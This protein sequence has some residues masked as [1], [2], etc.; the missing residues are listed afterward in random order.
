MAEMKRDDVLS[1]RKRTKEDKWG[2]KEKQ[3]G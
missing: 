3:E 1:V 2:R